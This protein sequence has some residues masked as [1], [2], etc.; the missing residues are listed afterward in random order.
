MQEE[1]YRSLLDYLNDGICLV[2]HQRKITYWSKGAERITGYKS[3]E[4]LGN[5]CPAGFLLRPEGKG[6]GLCPE[7]CPLARAGEDEGPCEDEILLQHKAGR[8]VP[9]SLRVAPIRDAGGRT[10]GALEIFSDRGEGNLLRRQLEDLQK[11]ALLD[12]LTRIPNRRY[13]RMV[14][15]SRLDEFQRFGWRFGVLFI[16]IDHFKPVNDLHGHEAGD[17][18]LKAVARKMHAHVRPFDAVG[19]WGGEEFLAVAANV[20]EVSLRALAERLR[21]L[22]EKLRVRIPDEGETVRVTISLGATL[23]RQGDTLETVVRRADRLMYRSKKAGRNQ[24][25][26]EDATS[27]SQSLPAKL[28]THRSLPP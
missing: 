21:V 8:R 27:G 23:P 19:R 11:V 13:L 12:P 10:V 22:V 20:D 18:V 25:S 16:D 3:A 24:L 7:G 14:L 26:F 15:R 9:V 4:V 2:D 17:R 5:G 1:F 6:A 28:P